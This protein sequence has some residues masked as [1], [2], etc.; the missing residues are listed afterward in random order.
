MSEATSPDSA[1]PLSP[2]NEILGAIS[3]LWWLVLLRGIILVVLGF[4]ALLAPGMTLVAFTQF[5]SFFLILDCVLAL[6]AGIMGWT[7]SRGWT[8]A[9]GL[10]GILVGIFVF[11]H[12]F[13]VGQFA[14]LVL[15]YIIAFQAIIAGGF[16]IAVAIKQR[17]QIEGEGWLIFSGILSIIF[18]LLLMIVPMF[19]AEFM[20]RLAGAFAILFGIIIAVTSFRMKSLGQG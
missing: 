2:R 10:L 14:A 4:Y 8:I 6:L 17:K 11:A 3:K 15:V 13:F 7:E 20:I 18:G 12:P 9:R 16:E 5:L 1:S 19:A